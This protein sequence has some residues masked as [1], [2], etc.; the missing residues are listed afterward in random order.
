MVSFAGRGH[1][2]KLS[3]QEGGL[4]AARERV[5][6]ILMTSSAMIVGM[7]P[8]ALGIGE[9]GDQTAPLGRA[10]IGGLLAATLVTLFLLPGIFS[11]VLGRSAYRSPSV[12]PLDPTSEHFAPSLLESMHDR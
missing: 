1:Q 11:I 8:M 6:A 5:R 10:V 3:A 7:I 4:K 2:N 12:N 9:G